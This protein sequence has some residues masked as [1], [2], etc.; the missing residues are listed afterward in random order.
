MT[1][2]SN[3]K[4]GVNMG[5]GLFCRIVADILEDLAGDV[6]ELTGCRSVWGEVELPECLRECAPED[7]SR[8]E[9]RI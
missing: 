6:L 3:L 7:G 8:P 2:Y 4:G 1:V 5:D 9:Q